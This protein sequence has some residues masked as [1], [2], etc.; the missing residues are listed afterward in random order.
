MDETNLWLSLSVKQRQNPC[1]GPHL[2]T[3]IFQT[4]LHT[5]PTRI[6]EENLIADQSFSHQ[7]IILL[8]LTTFSIDYA[9]CWEKI[10]FGHSWD[11]KG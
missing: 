9:F 4:D 10:D 3:G 7:V 6:G 1:S 2:C 11:L 8:I 5:F